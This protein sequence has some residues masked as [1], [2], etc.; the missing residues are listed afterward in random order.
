MKSLRILA[1]AL[2]L[3]TPLAAVH[4][5]QIVVG[6]VGPMSGMEASSGRAYAAGMQLV[7]DSVNKAGGVNGHTFTLV[8]KDDGGRP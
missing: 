2:A 4:A 7:F 6:Q 8:R 1:T 5:A 3:T